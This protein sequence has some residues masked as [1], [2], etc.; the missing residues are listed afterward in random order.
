MAVDARTNRA[1]V[2]NRTDDTV[3]MLDARSGAVLRTLPVGQ[4]PLSLAVDTRTRRVFVVNET[5]GSVS[6]LDARTGRRYR[7]VPVGAIRP[8]P[9]AAANPVDLAVDERWGHVFVL[10]EGAIDQRGRATPGT[11]SV[12]D[13]TSGRVVRTIAVGINPSAL[14]VDEAAGRL[15]VVNTGPPGPS[16]HQDP[17][18]WVP[19]WLRSWLP[20]AAPPIPN[21]LKGSVTLLDLARV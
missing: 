6:V 13:A 11:V 14:A 10:N 3:S 7:T 8:Q 9:E 18:G 20:W 2:T 21:P 4:G 5:A 1:F 12:L 16:R 19:P 17:Y 15:V